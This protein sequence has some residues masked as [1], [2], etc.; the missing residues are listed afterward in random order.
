[1]ANK[2][3]LGKGVTPVGVGS[4]GM[5]RPA[6]SRNVAGLSVMPVNTSPAYLTNRIAHN[7]SNY[8]EGKLTPKNASM[9]PGWP[10]PKSNN[11][12]S[13]STWKNWGLAP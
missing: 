2:T 6:P 9:M 11:F 8:S 10:Q 12:V 4:Y 3:P 1:M 5:N 7:L 13:S